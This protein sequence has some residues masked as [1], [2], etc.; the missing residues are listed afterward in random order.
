MADDGMFDEG[1]ETT[2]VLNETN[3]H[4]IE[5]L[6]FDSAKGKI[7]FGESV[8]FMCRDFMVFMGT[9]PTHIQM[10]ENAIRFDASLVEDLKTMGAV[11][12]MKDV[13]N[14]INPTILGR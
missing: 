8:D 3:W 7:V 4:N 13:S 5:N 9:L 12:T 6:T 11:I 1:M 10:S 14:F 2:N